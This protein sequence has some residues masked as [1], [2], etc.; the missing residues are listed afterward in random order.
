MS[1]LDTLSID[2]IAN[3]SNATKNIK[4]LTANIR[5]LRDTFNE[6]N[7]GKDS[8]APLYEGLKNI[9]T[10]DFSKSI[11]GLREVSS[12]LKSLETKG[13]GKEIANIVKTDKLPQATQETGDFSSGSVSKLA[14]AEEIKSTSN[15]LEELTSQYKELEEYA[16]KLEETFQTFYDN[17]M[18]EEYKTQMSGITSEMGLISS[19]IEQ[20]RQQELSAKLELTDGEMA[21][22]VSEVRKEIE[23]AS[24][25]IEESGN[26]AG[27]SSLS[28]RNFGKSLEESGKKAHKSTSKFSKF[29]QSLK[30]FS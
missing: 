8:L 16:V 29:L 27:L 17:G 2:V 14:G 11:D 10:L 15:E 22:A 4:K 5:S 9:A 21:N 23:E 18:I 26:K 3:T 13:I 24:E 7:V 28:I 30:T 25:K 19:K 12:I 20:I 6:M 1:V